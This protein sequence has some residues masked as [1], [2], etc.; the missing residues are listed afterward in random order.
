MSNFFDEQGRTRVYEEAYFKY[1]DEVN[2][3]R[4]QPIEKR[5]IDKWKLVEA[6]DFLVQITSTHFQRSG[7]FGDIILVL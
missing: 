4:T 5:A 2:P 7:S 1:V 6:L 3:R